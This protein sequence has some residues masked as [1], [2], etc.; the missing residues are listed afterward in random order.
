MKVLWSD[1][2][3]YPALPDD[4]APRHRSLWV[5]IDRVLDDRDPA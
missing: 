4:F 1:L 5:H 2:M 3:P